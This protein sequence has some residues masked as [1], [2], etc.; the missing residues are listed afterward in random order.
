[1]AAALAAAA[2]KEPVYVYRWGWEANSSYETVFSPDD[3]ITALGY[4]STPESL[5]VLLHCLETGPITTRQLA[6]RALGQRKDPRAI[7]APAAG[8]AGIRRRGTQCTR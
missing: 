1:M 7:P 4:T 6:A 5:D 2:Q 3:A 8:A